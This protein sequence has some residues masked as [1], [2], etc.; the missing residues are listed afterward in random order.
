MNA[1]SGDSTVDR[2]AG[3]LQRLY[4]APA[5]RNSQ[6]QVVLRDALR[7]ADRSEAHVVTLRIRSAPSPI[8][9]NSL[10]SLTTG[11]C[12]PEA[13]F[14]YA[15]P[16]TQGLGYQPPEPGQITYR[17]L[18][19][20]DVHGSRSKVGSCGW[21]ALHPLAVAWDVC[22]LQERSKCAWGKWSDRPW[23]LRWSR[24]SIRRMCVV[25]RG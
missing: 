14:R 7:D 24:A 1:S 17:K 9:Q 22:M 25:T 10:K 13:F 23:V 18:S 3:A 8:S 19:C 11:S 6:N 20:R 15:T 4:E 12:Y 21:P 2:R 16:G 5:D